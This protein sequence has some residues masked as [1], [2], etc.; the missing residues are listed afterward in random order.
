MASLTGNE[1]EITT[2]PGGCVTFTVCRYNSHIIGF[3]G[4]RVH[5][6]KKL[7]DQGM[8]LPT[9]A[10]CALHTV[11]TKCGRCKC[12]LTLTPAVS[13]LPCGHSSLCVNCDNSFTNKCFNCKRD[14]VFKL[15]FRI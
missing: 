6:L 11:P 5:L 9:D 8:L 13:C 2:Q 14:I 10:E 12:S 15:R 4:I 1:F 3:S 7:R